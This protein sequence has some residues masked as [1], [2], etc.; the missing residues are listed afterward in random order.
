MHSKV[1]NEQDVREYIV[2]ELVLHNEPFL[3]RQ[4]VCEVQNSRP[5]VTLLVAALASTQPY[6]RWER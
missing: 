2:I 1:H 3:A 6:R 5:F 4:S